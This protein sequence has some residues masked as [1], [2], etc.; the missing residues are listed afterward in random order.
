MVELEEKSLGFRVANFIVHSTCSPVRVSG[1]A[2]GG[3]TLD[4]WDSGYNQTIQP[5]ELAQRNGPVIIRGHID[6]VAT[7][8]TDST[9][10][11]IHR[12]RTHNE[13]RK[14]QQQQ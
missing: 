2:N 6:C 4:K 3:L 10:D 9:I 8:A 1:W 5:L 12:T 14:I 13:Q 7:S 11:Q